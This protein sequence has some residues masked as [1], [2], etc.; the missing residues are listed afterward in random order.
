[1]IQIE[2]DVPLVTAP[3]TRGSK[4]P[5]KDMAVGDSFAV[6]LKAQSLRSIATSYAKKEQGTVKFAVRIAEGGS[7]VWRVA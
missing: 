2:K 6:P 3:R 5:F 1:M 7:R 4:Y